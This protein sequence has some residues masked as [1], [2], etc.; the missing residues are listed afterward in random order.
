MNK[1]NVYKIGLS[2][3]IAVVV[4]N[5]V[6][7]GVFTSL[8]Y[9]VIDLKH[10]FTILM[11]W[12]V[13]GMLALFGSFA[14]GELGAS[15]PRNGGEYNFL[16]KIYHPLIGFLAGW[17]SIMIGF[18]A[19]IAA[20]A[21]A[22]GDYAI[23]VLGE[24]AANPWTEKLIAIGVSLAISLIHLQNLKAVSRFQKFFTLFKIV[25]IVVLIVL[26]FVLADGGSQISFAPTKQ[27]VNDMFSM[28][29]AGS[30]VW[31]MLAYSGW[32]AAAYIVDD[33]KKPGRNLPRSLLIGTAAVAVL[34]VLLNMMFLYVAPI[35]D[36]VLQKDV[37][38]VAAQHIF[39]STG[40]AI[41]SGL[42]AFA[43]I[44]AISSMI[45]A[46]PRVSSTIGEDLR[47]FSFLNKRNKNQVPHIAIFFQLGLI[48]PMIIFVPFG[49]LIEFT[50]VL[51][52]IFSFL[53]VL[54]VFVLRVKQPNLERPYKAWGYPVTPL[55]YLILT[56][57]MIVFFL[58]MKPS[59]LL[60]ILLTLVVGSGMYFLSKYFDKRKSK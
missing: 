44:S 33:M 56:G 42:I 3:A 18:A 1:Q 47:V 28:A 7:T 17:V 6:G 25:L 60:A 31:V 29:F 10:G 4:A 34:Y 24:D 22:M 32:N 41:V 57:W 38:N 55:I 45:W 50:S 20:A 27:S 53:A 49:D 54:G 52:S 21:L 16:S 35:N 8:G 12:A 15:L 9:Q 23:G 43:L 58:K 11:L 37:G 46:G 30:L 36:L 14:Y 26:G 39:G 40:A 5:M 2:T 51:L 19:P 48:I 13:G 59:I